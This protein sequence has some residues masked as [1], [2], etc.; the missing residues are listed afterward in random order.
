MRVARLIPLCLVL[1]ALASGCSKSSKNPVAPPPTAPTNDSPVNAVLLFRYGWEHRSVALQDTVLTDDFVFTPGAS[2]S[3]A[4]VFPGGIGRGT[5]LAI[6]QKL[7]VT[8]NGGALPA[9]SSITFGLD[10]VLNAV[11]STISGR[12]VTVHKEV[13]TSARIVVKTSGTIPIGGTGSQARFY[14]VRGDSTLVHGSARSTS[15]WYVEGVDDLTSGPVPQSVV[16]P[17]RLA[18]A[19]AL[20]WADLLALYR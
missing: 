8:G 14:V 15:R 17:A 6:D 10:N 1:I 18:G 13:L 4:V 16:R 19:H 3:A 11:N 9:A 20:T 2:D 7:F 12:N 5:F